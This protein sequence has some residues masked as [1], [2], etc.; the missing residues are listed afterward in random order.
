[1]LSHFSCS[2]N[3]LQSPTA[4]QHFAAWPAVETASAGISNDAH[5]P[6]SL[7]LLQWADLGVMAR[8]H[9]N[10]LVASIWFGAGGH[11]CCLFFRAWRS[12]PFTQTV[13]LSNVSF[14]RR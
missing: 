13:E 1:M 12:M 5:V 10:K 6:V 2:Q 8:T 7:A 4:D 9:R 14:L 11:A 3:R